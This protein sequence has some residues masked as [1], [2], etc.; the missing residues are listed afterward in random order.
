M[1]SRAPHR[2]FFG[3]L[4]RSGFLRALFVCATMLA[5]QGSMACAFEEPAPEDGVVLATAQVLE[6]SSPSTE[7]ESD[8]CVFCLDCSSCGGCHASATQQVTSGTQA[9][10]PIRDFHSALTTPTPPLWA[11]PALLRPPISAA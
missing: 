3:R 11:P 10:A 2:S 6:Q 5:S 9:T 7:D 1:S 8:C 4:R